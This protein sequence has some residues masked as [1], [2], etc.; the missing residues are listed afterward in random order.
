MCATLLTHS[1]ATSVLM[2]GILSSLSLWHIFPY[3][4]EHE[5]FGTSDIKNFMTH[6]LAVKLVSSCLL[7]PSPFP[8]STPQ[9]PCTSSHGSCGVVAF[10]ILASSG[11]AACFH[12]PFFSHLLSLFH[13]CF[14]WLLVTDI[15]MTY[16]CDITLYAPGD[17]APCSKWHTIAHTISD[18]WWC[19]LAEA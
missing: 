9:I 3:S 6:T 15:M 17:R 12:F 5:C 11:G 19:S 10:I 1:F 2:A 13:G 18:G 4:R 16:Q 14:E 8:L 7:P